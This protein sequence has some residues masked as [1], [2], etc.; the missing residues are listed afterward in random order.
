MR[1]TFLAF[2]LGSFVASVLGPL[3]GR[4]RAHG[5]RES[6]NIHVCADSGGVLRIT[7]PGAACQD[8]QRSLSLGRASAKID[9]DSP[10]EAASQVDGMMLRD[11]NRRL[12]KL[13]NEDCSLRKSGMRLIKV[14]S[15]GC[16]PFGTSRVVAPF[17]VVD[18]ANR[19]IF[20]V[21]T[22]EV[23]LFNQNHQAVANM[24]AG[25]GGGTF[26]AYTPGNANTVSFGDLGKNETSFGLKIAEGA[27][28]RVE[29]GKRK[30]GSYSL[31]FS[32]GGMKSPVSAKRRTARVRS[33]FLIPKVFR[34]L[35]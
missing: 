32:K 14:A 15:Q 5:R 4:L 21:N 8:G 6:G 23:T 7:A 16:S 2:L 30:S 10:I 9:L 25:K 17:S 13:E 34:K 11:L 22:G 27:D 3:V 12:I 19:P 33:A 20:Y 28:S 31:I 24:E 29:L 35:S 18:R 26:Y 1:R